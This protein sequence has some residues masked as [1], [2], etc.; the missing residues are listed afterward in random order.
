MVQLITG[1]FDL[2]AGNAGTNLSDFGVF[3]ITLIKSTCAGDSYVCRIQY[4]LS[5]HIKIKDLDHSISVYDNHAFV[6]WKETCFDAL[7]VN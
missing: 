2:K 1:P 5:A 7:Q 3:L 4:S 6:W